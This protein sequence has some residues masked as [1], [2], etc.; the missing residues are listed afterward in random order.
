VIRERRRGD[1]RRTAQGCAGDRRRQERRCRH[2]Q[3]SLLGYTLVRLMGVLS[4]PAS[5]RPL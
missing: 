2:G 1:R 3:T 4:S 5:R